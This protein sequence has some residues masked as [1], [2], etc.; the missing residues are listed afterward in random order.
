MKYG[1][2]HTIGVV[3][4]FLVFLI[5]GI[6]VCY[7]QTVPSYSTSYSP[8]TTVNSTGNLVNNTQ[9]ATPSTSTWQNAVFQNSLTCWA[10][11]DPGYCGPNPIVSPSGSINFSFGMVDLHQKVNVGKALPYGGSGLITTGYTFEWTSKNGNGWDDGRQDVL[12]AYVKLYSPGDTKVIESFNYNLNFIHNWT[13]FSYTET[14]QNTKVGYRENQV[15]N[16]QFGF[17]G[18]DNNYWA[19]PYGP[20]VNNVNFQLKYKPDPCKNNPLFSPECPNF[21]T[22]ISK[23]GKTTVNEP[24]KIKIDDTNNFPPPRE[25]RD[26]PP[27]LEFVDGTKEF[28]VKEHTIDLNRLSDT[29]TKITETRIIQEEKSLELAKEQIIKTEEQS[30]KVTKFAESIARDSQNKSIKESMEVKIDTIS[31]VSNKKE[32]SDSI[33]S[34]F[35]GPNSSNIGTNTNLL[36][37]RSVATNQ[38]L[39]RE[40]KEILTT[41]TNSTVTRTPNQILQQSMFTLSIFN[42]AQEQSQEVTQSIKTNNEISLMNNSPLPGNKIFTQNNSSQQINP[43]VDSSS[44]I[45]A[46]TPQANSTQAAVISQPVNISLVVSKP[47][48][49]IQSTQNTNQS[50]STETNIS[51]Y[52]LKNN[53]EASSLSV[54]SIVE[55]IVQNNTNIKID[56]PI[57]HKNFTIQTN[58][59]IIPTVNNQVDKAT[60]QQNKNTVEQPISQE[61]V[62]PVVALEIKAKDVSIETPVSTKNNFTEKANPLNEIINS[63]T[64]NMVEQKQDTK[65]TSVKSNVQDNDA[66]AGISIANIA[67]SPIGFNSYMVSLS[68]ANFYAPKE[69]Y[70]NQR[71]VDNVRALRQLSSDRLHQEMINQQ[72][73]R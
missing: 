15:G 55:P 69:I 33:L 49:V 71:T 65:T 12:S 18:M 57:I 29:L 7:G 34:L 59:I 23:I 73:R 24:E 22:E 11:G 51:T 10:W 67:K 64:I 47:T 38:S 8:P 28:G 53:L 6:T 56:E 2:K 37:P 14:W 46:I 70:R 32:S 43:I 13:T 36:G 26:R 50:V 66:A 45:T 60:I 17:V 54:E 25:E 21:N 9:T 44:Q 4:F 5:G 20:E 35:Q 40:N 42:K 19:G 1:Y 41:E 68:D 16:V 31:N 72:Y 52:Q 3:L 30:E 61:N 27:K 62:V 58:E 39:P 63:K 48:M